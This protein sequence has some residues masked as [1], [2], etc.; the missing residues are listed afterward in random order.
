MDDEKNDD[1]WGGT[2][3]WRWKV[4][5][6]KLMWNQGNTLNA[7]WAFGKLGDKLQLMWLLCCE[8]ICPQ[9][10]IVPPHKKRLQSQGIAC[11]G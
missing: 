6:V 3:T 9:N 1:D 10:D 7:K 11:F 4:D 8:P 5:D 2:S